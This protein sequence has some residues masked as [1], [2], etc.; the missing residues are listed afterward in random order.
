MKRQPGVS[1]SAA[2]SYDQAGQG[3]GHGEGAVG[4]ERPW[5][6]RGGSVTAVPQLEDGQFWPWRVRVHDPV[7]GDAEPL[8]RGFLPVKVDQG[9]T[10]RPACRRE[11]AE[12]LGLDRPAGRVLAVDWVPSRPERPE[13][14]VIVYDGG[15][16]SAADISMITLADGELAGVRWA[17]PDEVPAVVT[18]LLAR[19]I[20]AC[21]DAVAAGTVAALEDG[22]DT[23]APR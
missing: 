1:G 13:G 10:W 16:L 5:R 3:D 22:N 11:V 14:V 21:L 4:G 6:L 7:R 20:A 18:P 12:E 19:R 15:I 17:S 9:G 23:N 2:Q 8:V